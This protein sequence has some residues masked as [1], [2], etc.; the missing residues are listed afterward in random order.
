MSIIKIISFIPP[1]ETDH[2]TLDWWKMTTEADAAMGNPEVTIGAEMDATAD[3]IAAEIAAKYLRSEG[4]TAT[5]DS[6]LRGKPVTIHLT[7]PDGT[8]TSHSAIYS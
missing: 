1:V 3:A 8:E 5:C 7:A 4:Y 2:P 6:S